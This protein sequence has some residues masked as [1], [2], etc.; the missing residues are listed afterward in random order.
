MNPQP[1]SNQKAIFDTSETLDRITK[2]LYTCLFNV[3]MTGELAQVNELLKTGDCLNLTEADLRA[4]EDQNVKS[5]VNLLDVLIASQD[6]WSFRN[7]LEE[8]NQ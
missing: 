2:E 5:I 8:K 7:Q 3:A 1:Y 4:L 6:D